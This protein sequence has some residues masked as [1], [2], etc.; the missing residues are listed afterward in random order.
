MRTSCGIA[1]VDFDDDD[2]DG[3]DDDGD[4]G[5]ADAIATSSSLMTAGLLASLVV[6][7]TIEE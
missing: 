5:D 6:I 7:I 2:N 1:S 4:K 3:D